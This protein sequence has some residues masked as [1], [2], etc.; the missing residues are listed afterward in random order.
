MC[1]IFVTFAPCLKIGNSLW[2][3]EIKCNATIF[4]LLSERHYLKYYPESITFSLI[5]S[6]TTELLHYVFF[7]LQLDRIKRTWTHQIFFF[8]FFYIHK[9]GLFII[10]IICHLLASLYSLFPA[11]GPLYNYLQ[12]PIFFYNLVSDPTYNNFSALLHS[13][14]LAIGL[15]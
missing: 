15:P 4:P 14:F 10:I 11:I 8:S 12:S 9:S 1:V 7:H 2:L 6:H 13:L 5:C 3:T